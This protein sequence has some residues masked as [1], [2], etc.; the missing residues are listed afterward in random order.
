V[1][2]TLYYDTIVQRT[3]PE[4]RHAWVEWVVAHHVAR[5][6]QPDGHIRLWGYHPERAERAIRVVLLADGETVYNAFFDR[7]F[8]PREES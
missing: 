3:H 5:E 1:R 8:K 2:T 6:I 4:V 7:S